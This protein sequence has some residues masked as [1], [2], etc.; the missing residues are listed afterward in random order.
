M[1]NPRPKTKTTGW[2]GWLLAVLLGVTLCAATPA[3]AFAQAECTETGT[4]PTYDATGT[5]TGCQ[6]VP[7]TPSDTGEAGSDFALFLIDYSLGVNNPNGCLTCTFVQQFLVALASFSAAV[8]MY[9]RAFFVVLTPIVLS[10]WIGWSVGRLMVAGGD[11]GKDFFYAMI[12]KL[13]LFFMLWLV[14][15][16]SGPQGNQARDP[17]APMTITD[18]EAPWTWMGPD[19]MRY[20]FELGNEVR[21]TASQNL[22][23]GGG[24]VAG[25]VGMNCEGVAD[26]NTVLSSDPE[27]YAF[28]YHASE[29]ACAIE[30]IHIVGITSGWAMIVAA[31]TNLE[32]SWSVKEVFYALAQA[33]TVAVFGF[34]VIAVFGLSM[35]WFI[36]LLLDVVVKVLIVAAIAPILMVLALLVPT[37][38]YAWNAVRQSVGGIATLVGVAFVAALS[39]YLIAN[40]VTVYNASNGLYDPSLTDIPRTNT[41]ADLRAFVQRLTMETANPERIPMNISTPWYHYM[42]LTS[43]ST[44]VL[45]KKV[46]SIIESIIGARGMSEMAD[47]AKKIAVMG[48]AMAGAGA[49]F[50]LKA[51]PWVLGT[52]AKAGFAGWGMGKAGMQ[53]GQNAAMEMRTAPN[54]FDMGKGMIKGPESYNPMGN[55]ASKVQS[56][57]TGNIG[58]T[59]RSTSGVSAG[60]KNTLDET[61]PD[62]PR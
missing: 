53:W 42:L 6:F 49:Y 20:G 11:G 50:G 62:G 5:F 10:I 58:D 13:A 18:G 15:M 40:T 9:F 45:G 59:L 25:Q 8:F 37:R 33:M 57:K 32:L 34:F 1:H 24:N 47:N 39:F 41:T 19:L 44:Y 22:M 48:T 51:T 26:S 55:M 54:W 31:W 61:T 3:P 27:A 46:I 12:R 52:G 29:T 7:D 14:M 21:T 4:Q 23:V 56:L 2:I 17:S 60:I 35:I 36:F 38:P 43:L 30:R 28:A 16:Q